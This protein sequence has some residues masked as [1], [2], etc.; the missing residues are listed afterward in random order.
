MRL[1]ILKF[2]ALSGRYFVVE[3]GVFL[4][5]MFITAFAPTAIF[6][7]KKATAD[8][9][10]NELGSENSQ[11]AQRAGTWNVTE[12]V[13]DTPN[14]KPVVTKD[15]I[16]ERVMVG[17]MIQE[18]LRLPS[19]PTK[20]ILRMDYLTFNRVE[21]RWEYV[22]IDTRAA[23]GLMTAQSYGGEKEGRIDIIFQPFALPGAGQ[24]VSGQML[25]MRQEIISQAADR[26]VKDQYF[27]IADGDGKEWLAHRYSYVRTGAASSDVSVPPTGASRRIDEIKR[28]GTLRVAVLDEYPWLKQ[29]KTGSG[30]PFMGAA[31]RLAE[32]YAWRLGVK[33][34]T[35]P[36][37]FD[38]KVAV[39]ADDKVDITVAP[40]LAT[41]ERAK[42]VDLINY[43]MSA[44]CLFGRADNPKLARAE[45]LD[46]LNRSDITITYINDSPQGAWL[47]KRL[48]KA[49]RR[50]VSGN[51]ADVPVD[52]I[53][54]RR[55]DVTT[56]DKFFFAGLANKTP[57]LISIPKGNACLESQELPIPIGMAIAKNQ[58]EFLAW[59]RAVAQEIKPEIEAEQT[60]VEKLGS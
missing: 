53:T 12:T 15:L 27:T 6:A 39:L 48:P 25:R 1:S 41:P 28:R 5:L 4:A 38:N 21:G 36:V 31:W 35:V 17:S 52:E 46:D 58:P 9:R 37:N 55:A 20:K 7:Q 40:L 57:G 32:E 24:N 56:I 8:A 51:L 2:T 22:S 34:E 44:Q 60:E 19:D 29:N 45:S 10:M 3:R 33:L 11:M 49:V 42:T 43:S 13:W 26:D 50:G 30:R 16:A 23:V 18:T 59:L 47:Q 54:T 14:S